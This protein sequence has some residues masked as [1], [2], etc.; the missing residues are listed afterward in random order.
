MR[1]EELSKSQ[2]VLLTLLVSFVTSIATGIVTV[3]LMDQAPPAVAQT[4]NR[5][6]ERTVEKVVPS[7]LGQSAA[8]VTTE[9]TVIIKESDLIVQAVEK[10][11]PSLV[12]VYANSAEDSVF[13]GLGII[14]DAEGSVIVDN[15]VLSVLG[16]LREVSITLFD[17]ASLSASISSKDKSTGIAFL[18][19]ATTTADGK[20]ARFTPATLSMKSPVLGQTIVVLS[21]KSIPRITD[22]LV[23]AI[24]PRTEG[25]NP[26]VD[27]NVSSD[28]IMEGSPLISTEGVL[29]G[30]STSLSRESSKNGFIPASI[31]AG[32]DKSAKDAAMGE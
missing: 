26:I 30:I 2:I 6:I 25:E 15:S 17:G 32:K 11:T 24:I 9:K 12:R 8:V 3:S 21:G 28:F 4:V 23:T 19:P 1:M 31:L 7:P 18:K 5:I 22:G 10:I 27:T 29:L 14:L 13:L 20:I 16:D